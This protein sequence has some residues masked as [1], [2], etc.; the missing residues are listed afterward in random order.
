MFMITIL[1]ARLVVPPDLIMLAT[2]SA[3]RIKASGPELLPPPESDSR[4][5]RKVET[6]TPAPEPNLKIIPSFLIHW[7]IDSISSF[8]SRMKQA[9]HCGRSLTPT[10]NQTGLLKAAF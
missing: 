1:A 3:P 4:E 6:L 5:E 9:E 10:L 2:A 7:R 8:T